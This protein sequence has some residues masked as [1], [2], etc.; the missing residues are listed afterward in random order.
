MITAVIYR[1]ATFR[2]DEYKQNNFLSHRIFYCHWDINNTALRLSWSVYWWK[3]TNKPWRETL[4]GNTIAPCSFIVVYRRFRSVYCL[5]HYH[6][7]LSTAH[8]GPWPNFFGFSNVIR[9]VLGLLWTSDQPV[10]KASAYAGQHN[11]ERQIQTSMPWAR[12]KPA[13]PATKRPQTYALDTRPP[14][15]TPS[16]SGQWNVR[17]LLGDYTALYRRRLSSSYSP[18]WKPEFSRQ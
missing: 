17:L 7:H 15:P 11:T 6:L 4:L 18:P 9:R 14:G 3:K 8:A 2:G 12:F 16:S 1:S 13:I 10:A 5:H